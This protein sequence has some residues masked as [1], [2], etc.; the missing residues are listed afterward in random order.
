MKLRLLMNNL[1]MAARLTE[2]EIIDFG[3]TEKQFKYEFGTSA[4]EFIM[5]AANTFVIFGGRPDPLA[6]ALGEN[7]FVLSGTDANN[8]APEIVLRELRDGNT[9]YRT[10]GGVANSIGHLPSNVESILRDSGEVRQALF[11]QTGGVRVYVAKEVR[12]TPR[13]VLASVTQ[14]VLNSY[15]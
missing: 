13:E 6:A 8:L 12:I 7:D 10:V 1:E 5:D 4:A 11:R 14:L 15:R 3:S 2:F 9:P